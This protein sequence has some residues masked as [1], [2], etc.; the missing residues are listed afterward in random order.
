MERSDAVW[1]AD[2]KN[3]MTG[4]RWNR[5]LSGKWIDWSVVE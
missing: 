1:T 4:I 2:W 3:G 5:V